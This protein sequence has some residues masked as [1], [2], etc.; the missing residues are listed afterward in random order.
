[1]A[2]RKPCGLKKAVIENEVGLPFDSH[3]DNC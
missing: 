2:V 1:M 3:E